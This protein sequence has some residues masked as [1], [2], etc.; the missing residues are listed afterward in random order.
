MHHIT[1]SFP[2]LTLAMVNP[3]QKKQEV[4]IVPM[5]HGQITHYFDRHSL[6]ICHLHHCFPC[7]TYHPSEVDCH[8]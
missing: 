4:P 6:S 5:G 2:T 3:L 1:F 8:P 7:L